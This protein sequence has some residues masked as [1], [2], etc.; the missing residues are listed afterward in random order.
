MTIFGTAIAPV[1]GAPTVQWWNIY[2]VSGY[3]SGD[4][5]WGEFQLLV[6]VS[7]DVVRVE[8]YIDQTL[9]METD[10]SKWYVPPSKDERARYFWFS[11]D[12]NEYPPGRHE[13]QVKVYDA[14]GQVTTERIT[15]IFDPD[16]TRTPPIIIVLVAVIVVI[17]S[18]VGIIEGYLD[19]KLELAL[20]VRCPK[21]KA[22]VREGAYFCH[23]CGAGLLIETEELEVSYDELETKINEFTRQG[24]IRKITIMDDMG[25]VLV[26]PVA[27][28]RIKVRDLYRD[29]RSTAKQFTLIVERTED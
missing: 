18:T 2:K 3:Q 19:R 4:S 7:S 26:I 17:P 29:L 1:R 6:H 8:F 23:V 28:R 21:C 5:I 15:R 24:D 12:T 22:K 9:K 20:V 16:L 13:I 11:F 27:R 10:S 14:S 25:I